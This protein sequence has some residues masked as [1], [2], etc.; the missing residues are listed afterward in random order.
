MSLYFRRFEAFLFYGLIVAVPFQLRQIIYQ[1]DWIFNEW[2]SVSFYFT[3]ILLGVLLLIWFLNLAKG[4]SKIKIRSY[5]KWLLAFIFCALVSVYFSSEKFLSFF[6]W[7]KIAE[8]LLFYF[9]L[10]E[11]ALD[12]F[13]DIRILLAL[14]VGGFFQAVIAIFQFALQSSVGFYWL[15]E[16]IIGPNIPGVAVFYNSLGEKIMRAYGTTPHANILAGYLLISLS[17]IYAIWL[18]VARQGD[19]RIYRVLMLIYGIVLFAFFLTFSRTAIFAWAI[20]FLIFSFYQYKTKSPHWLDV[21][22][23][24]LLT[25]IIGILFGGL[26]W[27]E[28]SSRILISGSEEAVELRVYFAQESIDAGWN[29]FGV[30]TGNF[31]SWLTD[32]NPGQPF[33]RYQPVHNL[34]LL[35]YNEIGLFGFV[36]F[37]VFLAGIIL[38]QW[39]FGRKFAVWQPIILLGL[40]FFIAFFDHFLWTLQQ[41]R[42]IW[43]GVLAFISHIHLTSHPA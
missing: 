24:F 13:G 22:N 9:Y 11:Y 36:F 32:K 39:R 20:G 4:K 12:I 3:D 37:V 29:F 30:G 2:R 28:V 23:I 15:G 43:W 16:G 19:K 14:L 27:P 41:G 34:Y 17:A 21:K 31:V 10:R 35:V 38:E 18:G 5:D 6:S 42:F 7:L 25:L 26:F 8:F 33:W 1:A 40:V